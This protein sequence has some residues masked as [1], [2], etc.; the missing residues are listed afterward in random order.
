MMHMVSF[1]FTE[2]SL[3]CIIETGRM[4]FVILWQRARKLFYN[5]PHKL[6]VVNTL[7]VYPTTISCAMYDGCKSELASFFIY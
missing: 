5:T 4:P 7:I 1:L 6:K 3:S 2:V